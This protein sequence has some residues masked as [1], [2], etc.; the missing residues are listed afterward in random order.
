MDEEEEEE[1]EKEIKLNIEPELTE[2]VRVL[3]GRGVG[4]YN[5]HDN[6][7][8]NLFAFEHAFTHGCGNVE[9]RALV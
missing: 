5:F 2:A 4:V 7:T 9:S 8:K 1:E 3:E 6:K